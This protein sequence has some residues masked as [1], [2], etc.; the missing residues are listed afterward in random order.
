VCG[1]KREEDK[2]LNK[3]SSAEIGGKRRLRREDK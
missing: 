1:W 3:H 2:E